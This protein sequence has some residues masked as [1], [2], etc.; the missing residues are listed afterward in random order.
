M[1]NTLCHFGAQLP[2][3]AFSTQTSRPLWVMIACIIPDLPWIVIK[4]L[5]PLRLVDPYQLRLY[6]TG[7]AS[8]FCCLMLAA[9]LACCATH[10]LQIFAL[11]AANCLLHLL[12]DTVEIKWGNGVHLFLP[13]ST[14]M[15]QFDVVWPEHPLV[16]VFS[17]FG[18]ALLFVLARRPPPPPIAALPEK[19]W[20]LAAALL[21]TCYLAAPLTLM[22][23][24]ER[25]DAYYLRTLGNIE[26]RTGKTMAFDRVHFFADSSTL[27]TF[28]GEHIVVTGKVPQAS[29]RVSF[30]GH[31]LGPGLFRSEE[32]HYH[33]DRRDLATLIGL[34]MACALLVQSVI[35]PHFRPAKN[36]QGPQ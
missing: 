22:T 11:L 1:P 16:L 4:L 14:R 19:K 24:L 18:L 26:Q 21:L 33:R 28:A 30:R 7:Q 32:H 35:V 15:L 25:A 12:L 31:F 2:F 34:F 36:S 17:G 3:F 9:A 23:P 6:C 29:G 27:R 8:L 13:F 10:R 5:V 20:A